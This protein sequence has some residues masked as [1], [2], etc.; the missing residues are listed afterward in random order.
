MQIKDDKTIG[1]D[2]S[3]GLFHLTKVPNPDIENTML[4]QVLDA[5]RKRE[6]T[7]IT[8]EV[9]TFFS[10]FLCTSITCAIKRI[11]ISGF[12]KVNNSLKR[13]NQLMEHG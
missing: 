9:N 12:G 13:L 8:N 4:A 7:L 2:F 10:S 3:L 6:K 5:P 11:S 1:C